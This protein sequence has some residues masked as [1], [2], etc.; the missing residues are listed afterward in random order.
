LIIVPQRAIIRTLHKKIKIM[1][2]NSKKTKSSFISR[3]QA[4]VLVCLAML[5]IFG[6]A[7]TSYVQAD[8]FQDQID[9][10]A[11]Q[12]DQKN[13]AKNQLGAE[14]ASLTDAINKLQAQIDALQAKINDNKTKVA[15]LNKQIKEAEEELAT[16]KKLLGEIIKQM[17]LTGDISTVEMLASS[18]NLS[19][20]FDKQQYQ[21]SVQSKVKTTLDKITQLKLD[22]ST[23]KEK[24]EKFIAEQKKLQS[25]LGSQRAQKDQLLGLNQSQQNQLNSQIEANNAKIG[26]LRAE[27][28]AAYAAYAMANGVAIYGTGEA[29]NGGYPS[30]LANAPQDSIIDNWGL[31]NRECVSYVAWKESSLGRY[32][33]YGLGNAAD[34][35]WRASAAGIPVDGNPTQGAAAVWESND[36]LGT[37]GHVAYVEVVNGDRSIEVSQYNFVHGSF[38]RMHVPPWDAARLSYVHF[39]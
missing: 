14:A 28:A 4:S 23:Q 7:G 13:G 39:R 31:Y 2:T 26:Q 24:V 15:Q 9:A 10:L 3:L 5:V 36:G 6:S 18:K 34:W 8:R 21:E 17:Y 35:G 22:L 19:D 37:L 1:K 32:V 38:N 29:G 12:N 27:Q 20:F 30:V 33:P 25:Q 11:A 16:Q